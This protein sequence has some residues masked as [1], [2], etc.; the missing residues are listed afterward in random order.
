MCCEKVFLLV[1]VSLEIEFDKYVKKM[2]DWIIV[3]KENKCG[4]L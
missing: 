2:V 4:K 3:Y 1:F